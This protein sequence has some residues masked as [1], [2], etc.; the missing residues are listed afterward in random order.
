MNARKIKNIRVETAGF[1]DCESFLEIAK[2][3]NIDAWTVENYQ[4]EI[5]RSDSIVLKA[6]D[7]NGSVGFLI[8]RIVPGQSSAYDA[9]IYNIAVKVDN[10][11]SGIG[12]LLLDNLIDR[13]RSE[14]VESVWLEV[15]KSNDKAISFYKRN[16]FTQISRRP[17]FYAN[18]VED[19]VLMKINLD[20]DLLTEA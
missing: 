14:S 10:Q 6:A 5:T 16:G 4:S 7:G 11:R 18:P 3:T 17:A 12:K 1:E 2:E 19:A 20:G 8:A 13:L 15:R 9:E